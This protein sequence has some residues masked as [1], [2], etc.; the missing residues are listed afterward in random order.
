MSGRTRKRV[1]TKDVDGTERTG[2]ALFAFKC[3][4]TREKVIIQKHV[5]GAF[6]FTATLAA[7]D[8]VPMGGSR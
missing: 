7:D 3:T 5:L 4:P 6:T 2:K 8:A 1:V